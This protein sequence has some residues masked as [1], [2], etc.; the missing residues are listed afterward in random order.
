MDLLEYAQRLVARGNTTHNS[1][2]AYLQTLT[3]EE[4]SKITQAQ[5]KAEQTN[6]KN[7]HANTYLLVGGLI[8]L[9]G[10]VLALGY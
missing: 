5:P 3:I 9:F 2:M 6:S 1:H 8:L 10:S 7:S 4:P